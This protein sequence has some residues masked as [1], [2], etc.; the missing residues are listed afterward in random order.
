M[1]QH[2][3]PTREAGPMNEDAKPPRIRLKV[4]LSALVYALLTAAVLG[5][6]WYDPI[7]REGNSTDFWDAA[8]GVRLDGVYSTHFRNFEAFPARDGW[9]IY[10]PSGLWCGVP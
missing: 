10:R 3:R 1:P 6:A 8:A 2:V 4:I 9:L 7:Y 5:R